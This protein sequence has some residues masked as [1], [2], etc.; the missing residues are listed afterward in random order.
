M[1]LFVIIPNIPSSVRETATLMLVLTGKDLIM[2]YAPSLLL[3]VDQRYIFKGEHAFPS[4]VS[5]FLMN[6]DRSSSRSSL[7][8]APCL[9]ALAQT[10]SFF[11]QKCFELWVC[12]RLGGTR[13]ALIKAPV[14]SLGKQHLMLSDV[15]W[16]KVNMFVAQRCSST[17]QT[18]AL[19]NAKGPPCFMDFNSLGAGALH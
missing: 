18:R 8:S 2:F 11:L 13:L 19:L 7:K 16:E 14:S 10:P 12:L 5:N 9:L 4:F 17:A 6:R 15:C 3:P 1:S